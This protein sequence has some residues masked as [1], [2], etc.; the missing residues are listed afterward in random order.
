[1]N[2][3]EEKKIKKKNELFLCFNVDLEMCTVFST[4]ANRYDFS[5][6]KCSVSI[7]MTI[8][9]ENNKKSNVRAPKMD[10]KNSKNAFFF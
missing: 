7:L 1:L 9:K 6:K 8:K 3:V 2:T 4:F 5:L 10:S